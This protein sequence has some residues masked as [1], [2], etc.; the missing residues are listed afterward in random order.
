M[1]FSSVPR[2][3]APAK[4][5]DAALAAPLGDLGRLALVPG[6]DIDFVN[7]DFA[8]QFGGRCPSRQAV[9]Q[10][11]GHGLHVRAAQTKFPSYRLHGQIG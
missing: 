3:G 6:D 10:M 8:F 1:S 7:L 9:A 4:S 2:P 11:L 5:A